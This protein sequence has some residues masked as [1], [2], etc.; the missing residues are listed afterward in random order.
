VVL[1]ATAVFCVASLSTNLS[2]KIPLMKGHDRAFLVWSV[3]RLIP[4]V[5][6]L[7]T[8]G[9]V[10]LGGIVVVQTLA[11]VA[12]LAIALRPVR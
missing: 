9:A 2:V 10:L 11:A 5:A 3:G 12:F 1:A 7:A 6:L 4:L 8:T